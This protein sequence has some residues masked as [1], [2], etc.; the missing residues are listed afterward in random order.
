MLRIVHKHVGIVK[1]FPLP[2]FYCRFFILL[3]LYFIIVGYYISFKRQE[4]LSKSKFFCTSLT[5][6]SMISPYQQFN[7]HFIIFHDWLFFLF[8][9]SILHDIR[10][11]LT[12][13]FLISYTSRA[14][15]REEPFQPA[16]SFLVTHIYILELPSCLSQILLTS[17]VF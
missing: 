17:Q 12:S 11:I 2:L 6:S 13:I 5:R 8:L 10:C 14:T 7:K 4:Q 9:V 15:H 16:I 1:Y 3:N